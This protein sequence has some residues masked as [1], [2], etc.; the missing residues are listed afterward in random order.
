MA[1]V[2][3]IARCGRDA[4]VAAVP[5]ARL[6]TAPRLY[7]CYNCAVSPDG[8][9]E[10]ARVTNTII[11]GR[12][13]LLVPAPWD[14]HIVWRHVGQTWQYLDDSSIHAT[15]WPAADAHAHGFTDPRPIALSTTHLALLCY[16][17]VPALHG[18]KPQAW[19]L[20]VR[21]ADGILQTARHLR[22]LTDA[23]QKNWVARVSG[24]MLQL[25]VTPRPFSLLELPLAPLVSN[26]PAQLHRLLVP[27]IHADIV[28]GDARNW[29]NST[30]PLVLPFRGHGLCTW[31]LLHT[32]AP[33]FPPMYTYRIVIVHSDTW[34]PL[35]AS[36]DFEFSLAPQHTHHP[37]IDNRVRPLH[38]RFIYV[39]GWA[40]HEASTSNGAESA[41]VLRITGGVDDMLPLSFLLSCPP[42]RSR[43]ELLVPLA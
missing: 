32:R 40:L 17:E 29:S 27:P 18:G 19:L 16:A 42:S 25:V 39:S 22:P 26:E 24:D 28:Q 7:T 21:I 34:A 12:P 23:P 35:F 11:S 15:L 3:D 31:L 5:T 41:H 13:G 30:C 38:T 43:V 37:D 8:C 33:T 9:F 36:Q 6:L 10:A 14:N 20:I 2:A 1:I 4:A